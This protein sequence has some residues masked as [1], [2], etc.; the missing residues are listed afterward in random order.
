MSIRTSQGRLSSC[1]QSKERAYGEVTVQLEQDDTLFVC[2]LL[3]VRG[4]PN[5]IFVHV[6]L[7]VYVNHKPYKKAR[8]SAFQAL[9]GVMSLKERVEI[10]K[11]DFGRNDLSTLQIIVSLHSKKKRLAKCHIGPRSSQEGMEHWAEMLIR[12]RAVKAH[13]FLSG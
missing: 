7:G 13:R 4:I 8:S 3:S 5:D 12:N 6:R 2:S 9:G 11:S 10:P 1:F